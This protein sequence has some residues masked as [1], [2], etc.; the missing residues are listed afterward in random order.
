MASLI[1]DEIIVPQPFYANYNSFAL[2][3]GVK[4]VPITTYIE[5]DF[6]LPAIETFESLIT[7]KTKAILICN[8][9]NPTGIL[10]SLK[11]LEKLRDIV[12]KHDLYLIADE[13]YREFAY[14]GHK[15]HSV[16]SFPIWKKKQS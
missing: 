12:V 7:P 4:V 11:A 14:D 2:T 10:Y 3:A 5:N 15:H 6:D 1:G 8:P 9:G 13:V 16:F